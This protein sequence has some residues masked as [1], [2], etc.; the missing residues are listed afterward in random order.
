MVK[1]LFALFRFFPISHFCVSVRSATVAFLKSFH[2]SSISLQ[3]SLLFCVPWPSK[4][5]VISATKDNSVVTVFFLLSQSV[6]KLRLLCIFSLPLCLDK[7]NFWR[8]I[9]ESRCV[10]T[11]NLT[12]KQRKRAC[13]LFYIT[14][15]WHHKRKL[16]FSSSCHFSTLHPRVVINFQ[17]FLFLSLFLIS[18]RVVIPRK[19]MTGKFLLFFPAMLK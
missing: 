17:L 4:K 13:Q 14:H 3:A 10:W 18:A 6:D 2:D 16:L 15:F 1:T 5:R 8:V 9:N 12:W 11:F 19:S 7:W